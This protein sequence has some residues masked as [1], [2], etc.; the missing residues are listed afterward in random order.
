MSETKR[1]GKKKEFDEAKELLLALNDLCKEKNIDSDFLLGTLETALITAYKRNFNSAQNV[2]VT[3]D[4]TTGVFKVMAEKEVVET[5]AVEETEAEVVEDAPES[6]VETT[7]ATTG[8]TA[9]IAA[10]T[11]LVLSGYAVAMTRKKK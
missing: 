9:A 4:K 2:K 3:I 8:N 11:A 10:A 5:E 7:P 6:D 1:K